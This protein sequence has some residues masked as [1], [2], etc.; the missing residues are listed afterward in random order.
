[1]RIYSA[2]IITLLLTACQ[3]PS[4]KVTPHSTPL[5]V[6]VN[7]LGNSFQDT[8]SNFSLQ[9]QVVGDFIESPKQVA[10]TVEEQTPMDDSVAAQRTLYQLAYQQQQWRIINKY[11]EQRC[12]AGRGSQQY[13]SA[14]CR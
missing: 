4:D 7:D 12:K 14:L 10:I 2:L 6:V 11:I 5:Q 1:M 9:Q 3:T 13:S 8:I